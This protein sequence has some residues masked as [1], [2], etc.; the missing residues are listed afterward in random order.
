MYE[1]ALTCKEN[2]AGVNSLRKMPLFTHVVF[3]GTLLS[4]LLPAVAGAA[5][6]K[7][8]S[9]V[10]ASSGWQAPEVTG[11]DS[12]L[13]FETLIDILADSRVVFV[14]ESHDR[15]DHH[16]NQLEIICR[17]HRRNPDMVIAMEFFQQPFQAHLDDFVAG[18]IDTE[19]MLRATEYY[20]R[21]RF[22]YRLYEPIMSFAR[23]QGIAIVALNLAEE[24]TSKVGI[25]GID[26]L[27]EE[28]R[29]SLPGTMERSDEQ[30]RERIMIAF[31]LHP[32]ETRGEFERF[33]EVQLLWDE[34]MAER[35]AR[36]LIER[37]ESR[38]VVLAGMGH[39]TRSGIPARLAR[40][41][42]AGT[43]SV[44]LQGDSHDSPSFRKEDGDFILVSKML[45]LPP[46]G[47]LGVMLDTE[48]GRV[49]VQA[50]ADDSAAE[51]AGLQT[52]DRIVELQGRPV[53]DFASIKMGLLGKRPGDTVSVKVERKTGD[54]SA[55]TRLFE[56]TLR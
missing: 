10:A 16:L 7:A 9:E 41:A 24:I 27:S 3:L 4:S 26:S 13:D 44:V 6:A 1:P 5:S 14:G 11:G 12:K 49:S 48:A 37:P 40:R 23:T 53:S 19:D 18:R 25:G 32:E 20:N 15:Y 36:F 21:W 22:D 29:A 47:M 46:A 30:Y 33:F 43:I 56:V 38:L 34:G 35:A 45:E 54:D 8:C 2:R 52:G 42:P 51:E 28:E 31:E 39:A 17:L 50:F 55:A